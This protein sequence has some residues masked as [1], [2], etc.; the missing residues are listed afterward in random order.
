[1][2][3]LHLHGWGNGCCG[4]PVQRSIMN[5]LILIPAA[6]VLL[7]II[8]YFSRGRKA[9][10]SGLGPRDDRTEPQ[11]LTGEEQWRRRQKR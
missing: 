10:G 11:E 2:R 8:L 7:A 5:L 1:M 3:K 6:L 4:W 9:P